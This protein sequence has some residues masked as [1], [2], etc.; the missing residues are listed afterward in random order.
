M[1][2][3]HETVTCKH[4]VGVDC[5]LSDL[6]PVFLN[7][8]VRPIVPASSAFFNRFRPLAKTKNKKTTHPKHGLSSLFAI[9]H[10]RAP[11]LCCLSR[12]VCVQHVRKEKRT[13]SNYHFPTGRFLSDG[14]EWPIEEGKLSTAPSLA[15]HEYIVRT[16]HLPPTHSCVFR[17]A[18]ILRSEFGVLLYATVRGGGSRRI[19]AKD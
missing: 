7:R 5:S 14:F 19:S 2:Q 16:G 15:S 3:A 8:G 18:A 17:P 9:A 6:H 11:Q 10:S 13:V 4:P 1:R 12:R